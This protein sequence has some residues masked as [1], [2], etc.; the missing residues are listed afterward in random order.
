MRNAIDPTLN[1]WVDVFIAKFNPGGSALVY[2]TYIGG[3]DDY[4]YD[5]G[6]AI[7]V[8]SF[9]N[10]Y[11][12][13]RAGSS[14]FLA[15]N[16]YDSTFNGGLVDG[17]VAKIVETYFEETSRTIVYTGAWASQA[18]ALCS[19]GAVKQTNVAGDRATFTFN[20]RGVTWMASRTRT[21]GKAKVFV[22]GVWR[23]TVNLY[24]YT[25]QH[26]RPVYTV[27][28]LAAGAHTLRSIEVMGGRP[29]ASNYVNIDAFRVMP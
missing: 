27:T 15:V 2:S 19:A 16:A 14:D 29:A 23:A 28:G 7:A 1:G 18:C 24:S 13:G 12:T 11:V 5:S 17:F 25:T 10:A 9:D 8:D 26:K 22:D 3:S 6:S 20:G 4:Y 21:S